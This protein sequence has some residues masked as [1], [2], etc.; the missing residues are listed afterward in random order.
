MRSHSIS[1]LNLSRD[2]ENCFLNTAVLPPY[3]ILRYFEICVRIEMKLC[4]SVA[5]SSTLLVSTVS[6]SKETVG[7]KIIETADNLEPADWV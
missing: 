4:K 1:S 5:S 3:K 6:L 2:K 7:I